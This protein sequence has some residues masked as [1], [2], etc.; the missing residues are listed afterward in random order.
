MIDP[1]LVDIGKNTY[2]IVPMDPFTALE[3][4]GDLQ[5]AIVPVIG[6]LAVII[7]DKAT[8]INDLLDKGI[9]FSK[10]GQA[11]SAASNQLDGKTIAALAKKLITKE[12]ITVQFDGSREDQSRMD[13]AAVAR[14][15]TGKTQEMLR[16]IFKIAEVNYG[17][18][19]SLI[20]KDFGKALAA[21]KQQKK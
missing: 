1:K 9:D 12:L 10:I 16:L 6:N 15:F 19:L 14:A 2:G 20:P 7:D 5:K 4:F 21:A 11:L 18:F 3:V 13:D 17:D 8:S